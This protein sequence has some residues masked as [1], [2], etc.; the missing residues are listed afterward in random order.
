[1]IFFEN[2]FIKNFQNEPLTTI[3]VSVKCSLV[4]LDEK[5]TD[6]FNAHQQILG[7]CLLEIPIANAKRL[8]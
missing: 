1:M 3:F 2:Y 8:K 6:K 7:F 4:C 5:D